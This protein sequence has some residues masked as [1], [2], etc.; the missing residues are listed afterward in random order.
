MSVLPGAQTPR[1]RGAHWN[2]R[3]CGWSVA[4]PVTRSS[5]R[6]GPVG[7][8]CCFRF[9]R[10]HPGR[11]FAWSRSSGPWRSATG[12]GSGSGGCRSESRRTL[13]CRF[14][15]CASRTCRSI[16]R[17][18]L[19][20]VGYPT[21]LIEAIRRGV[22]MFDCVAPTRNGRNGTAFT[23]AGRFNVKRA[24]FA[25]DFPPPGRRLRLRALPE[26]HPGLPATPVRRR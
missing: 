7:L 22:D 12:R 6:T 15:T 1:P 23:T 16:G 11:S 19:M 8:G 3:C 26:L 21:D 10:A 13:P 25:R 4:G 9:F 18:T 14:S 24:G 2:E 20:G 17:A 5:A